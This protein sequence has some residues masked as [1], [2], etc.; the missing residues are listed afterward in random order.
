MAHSGMI[1]K[2]Q[3]LLKTLTHFHLRL[4]DESI[5][6]NQLLGF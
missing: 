4:G 5:E 2:M 6:M 1:L 3:V